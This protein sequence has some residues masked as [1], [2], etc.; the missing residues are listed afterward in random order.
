MSANITTTITVTAG[1]SG[2]AV[3]VYDE[4]RKGD[5]VLQCPKS[6]TDF[7]MLS[8]NQGD[9]DSGTNVLIG[10]AGSKFVFRNWAGR[11]YATAN[12]GTQ[13]II[14]FD[15]KEEQPIPQMV[16]EPTP[17]EGISANETVVLPQTKNNP[18]LDLYVGGRAHVEV[19]AHGPA[20]DAGTKIDVYDSQDG[21][22]WKTVEELT[23]AL[24]FL[25]LNSV[26]RKGYLNSKR[27]IR[28]QYMKLLATD[29]IMEICASGK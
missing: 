21:T 28:I 18:T 10:Y 27:Y 6:N 7:V 5:F 29:Y 20:A 12:S 22:N 16:P 4:N 23:L 9:V 13:V 2:G 11:I 1:Q 25:G 3:A 14:R 17:D 19:Y 8:Y 26:A 24:D 15:G